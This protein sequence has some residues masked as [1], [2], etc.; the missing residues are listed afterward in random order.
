[1][2]EKQ[3]NAYPT[4]DRAAWAYSSRAAGLLHL[5]AELAGNVVDVVERMHGT[6]ERAPLPLSKLPE[7]RTWG[8]TGLVYRAIRNS[9]A[10]VSGSIG[11]IAQ[12]LDNAA[13]EQGQTADGWLPVR[14]AINGVCGDALAASA[15]PLA[16][17]MRVVSRSGVAGSDTLVLFAHGL[18]MS[19]SGW[20]RGD[21]KAFEAWCAD[22]FGARTAHLR[23]NT[24]L[25]I[26]ANAAELAALLEDLVDAEAVKRLVLIGHSMGGLLYRSACH[27]A[28]EAGHRWPQ[29]VSHIVMLGSPH[30]GSPWERLGNHANR[31]LKFSPY[32]LPLATFGDLRSSGIKD[33]RHG[34]LL[35]SDWLNVDPDHRHDPRQAV[36]LLDTASHMAVAASRSETIPYQVWE[37][38]D[39]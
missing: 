38:R 13:G 24:G 23:Y 14:A 6:I 8:I 16:Q 11:R 35:E 7:T 18:C 33:L 26:S 29:T 21:F 32:T 27:Q 17:P 39:D 3:I 12:Q 10:A 30:N 20:R 1:M 31:L 22:E 36:P 15:N 28:G 37:A 9:F 2:S 25:R 5:G 4:P 19:E 34:N